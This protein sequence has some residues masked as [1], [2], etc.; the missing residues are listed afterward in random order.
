[1]LQTNFTKKEIKKLEAVQGCVGKV[2]IVGENFHFKYPK[3]TNRLVYIT[4]GSYNGRNGRISNFWYWK[5]I[6]EDG[7]LGK[8]NNGYGNFF[9]P[10]EKYIPVVTIIKDNTEG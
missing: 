6:E 3:R 7:T 5:D 9:N 10:S 8:S 1:M 2:Y 4:G